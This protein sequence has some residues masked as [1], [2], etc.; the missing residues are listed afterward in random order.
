MNDQ[1]S[2]EFSSVPDLID[3]LKAKYGE[4]EPHFGS[5]YRFPHHSIFFLQ[6]HNIKNF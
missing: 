5:K 1:N 6:N 4:K 2:F 3:K